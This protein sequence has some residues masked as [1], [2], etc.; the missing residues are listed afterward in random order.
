MKIRLGED[1]KQRELVP[2]PDNDE[3]EIANI[4]ALYEEGSDDDEYQGTNQVL[5]IRCIIF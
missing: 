4:P 2:I 1:R 5:I 3:C